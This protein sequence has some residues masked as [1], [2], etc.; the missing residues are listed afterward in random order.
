MSSKPIHPSPESSVTRAIAQTP[1]PISLFS[2]ILS[3]LIHLPSNPLLSYSVFTSSSCP[4]SHIDN[5]ELARREIL[6]LRKPAIL[7]SVLCSVFIDRGVQHLYAFVVAS[8]DDPTCSR[9]ALDT[10]SFNGLS[11]SESSCFGPND[12]YPSASSSSSSPSSRFLP[13]EPLRV[14]H[15]QFLQAV[16]DR[17]TDDMCNSKKDGRRLS[18]LKDGFLIFPPNNP[19]DWGLGWEH[20]IYNRSLI[21]C[22]LHLNFTSTRILVQPILQPTYFLPLLSSLPLPSGTPITLLPYGTPAYF[23]TTYTGPASAITAQFSQ[24][25]TGL[26]CSDW[27]APTSICDHAISIPSVNTKPNCPTYIITWINVQNKQGEEK[28]LTAIW[29]A[30]LALSFLPSAPVPHA[31]QTLSLI[32]ELPTQLQPSPPPIPAPAPLSLSSGVAGPSR[33]DSVGSAFSTPPPAA[34][35]PA[36]TRR[37]R[38]S[39][40]V[41]ALRVFRTLSI[42]RS[43]SIRAVATE[44]SGYVDAVTKEREKERERLRREREGGAAHASASPAQQNTPGP[45]TVPT[46]VP[47]P[48]TSMDASM[49]PVAEALAQAATTDQMDVVGAIEAVQVPP[50]QPFYPSPPQ[51]S[52]GP[53]ISVSSDTPIAT[54]NPASIPLPPTAAPSPPPPPPP[55][56]ATFDPVVFSE[57]DDWAPGSAVWPQSSND[58]MDMGLDDVSGMGYGVGVGVGVGTSQMGMGGMDPISTGGGAAGAWDAGPMDIDTGMDDIF[59]EADFDFWDTKPAAAVSVSAPSSSGVQPLTTGATAALGSGT[60]LTPS[61]GPAPLGLSPPLFNGVQLSGPGPPQMGVMP[62]GQSHLSPWM[63]GTLGEGF[64]Q[65]GSEQGGLVLDVVPP[66]LLPPSPTRTLSSHSAPPTPAVHIMSEPDVNMEGEREGVRS[67][68]MR[69]SMW[70][71][72][73]FAEVHRIADG[74]YTAGKFALPS[75]PD[76][77]DRTRPLPNSVV[78]SATGGGGW[79]VRYNAVTNPSIGMVRKLIGVKRK[80]FDQGAREAGFKI[81]PSWIRGDDEWESNVVQEREE[82]E[83]DAGKSDDEEAE[84]DEDEELW[85]DDEPALPGT[86]P[87]TPAPRA[88]VSPPGLATTSAPMSVPTPVSPAALVGQASEKLKSLEAAAQLLVKEVV[89]SSV[90]GD[91]WRANA[92]EYLA[93]CRLRTEVWQA[94]VKRVVRAFEGMPGIESPLEVKSVFESD[95]K[96]PPKLDVCEVPMLSVGKSDTIIQVLP[97]AMRFWEKLGLGPRAGKK[98]VVAFVFF[99][100]NEQK[101]KEEWAE[102]WLKCISASYEA[103]NL[104]SHMAGRN[105]GCTKDGI[106]PVKFDAFRKTLSTFVANLP[107][108]TANYVFFSAVK[109]AQKVY[110]EAQILFQFLPAHLIHSVRYPSATQCGLVPF[111][112]CVYE[113][114]L[115]PVDRIMSRRFSDHGERVRNFFQEPAVTLARPVHNKVHLVREFPARTLDVLERH[116]LL[117][118]G[119]RVSACGKWIFAAC[120]DQRGEAHDLGVWLSQSEYPETHLVQQLWQFA[121]NFAKKAS[122]EWRIVFAR[123]GSM[124]PA[125]LDA[126]MEHLAN[127]VP[128]CPGLPMVHVTLLSVEADASWTFI[129]P[130]GA[131]KRTTSPHRS[132]KNNSGIFFHDVSSSTHCL[133]YSSR[134]S[135]LLPGHSTHDLGTRLSYVPDPTDLPSHSAIDLPL[136]P[137]RSTTLIRTPSS[138]DFTSISMLH[139]HLLHTTKSAL[140]SLTIPDEDTHNDIAKNYHE[141]VV[142]AQARWW[143]K[144][145][146]ILPFHLGALEVMDMALISPDLNTTT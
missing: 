4:A 131:T 73:P 32:P 36:I 63:A 70:D 34:L 61:A 48:A 82:D 13:R 111:V 46:P 115:R 144:A 80:S 40:T 129:A 28:G 2:P 22:Y 55:P 56:A 72:I 27:A 64:V 3:A 108:S 30:S 93:E 121:V 125:E 53:T 140:S 11:V 91:A 102:R 62:Q 107:I 6:K 35:P 112:V 66:E 67:G 7:D 89:E 52:G 98:D 43:R 90:W 103:K 118:V 116:T 14:A 31:Q 141:L 130:Q 105:V 83:G 44:V 145:S 142:L 60:G 133:S 17:L 114:I 128:D 58:F 119:Y 51:S 134:M 143:L 16:R 95:E 100:D 15:S 47:V 104:G 135:L 37:A 123:L 49:S 1:P 20:H 132:S 87:S 127:V 84:S 101:V 117:H 88:A 106:V 18:K 65:R 126:W 94:D 8:A 25:L 42:G 29:P 50:P 59:T 86:R 139:I 124:S 99:E 71:P 97:T 33:D 21:H 76:E 110:S 78:A 137:L 122:V 77:E 9:G 79:R 136:K 120:I 109:R 19:S 5:I 38:A 41:D 24:S 92:L 68:S 75:P 96:V 57:L 146:P 81:S 113:R 69:M 39:P 23:L 54:S 85:V 45:T 138:T 10:L 26:G 12:I 74:K